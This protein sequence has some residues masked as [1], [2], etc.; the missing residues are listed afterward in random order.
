MKKNIEQ[1]EGFIHQNLLPLWRENPGDYTEDYDTRLFMH[2]FDGLSEGFGT[3]IREYGD[4]GEGVFTD[5]S[6]YSEE[7]KIDGF[8][9]H[10]LKLMLK[11]PDE[12][13]KA[14][15]TYLDCFDRYIR[16]FREKHKVIHRFKPTFS[17]KQ[18]AKEVMNFLKMNPDVKT[19]QLRLEPGGIE[20]GG[21]SKIWYYSG[22]VRKCPV[23]PG[24]PR[25]SSY[26][27]YTAETLKNIGLGYLIKDR[28][29]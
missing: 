1:I 3:L 29:E 15:F 14:Y 4:T 8:R 21:S 19:D 11:Y 5:F 6:H 27:F 18:F 17:K 22:Y 9:M 13:E 20:S 2:Y 28:E 26:V 7:K 12:P 16:K 24:N 10:S 25:E 23:N